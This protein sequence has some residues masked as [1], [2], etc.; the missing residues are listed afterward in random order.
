LD[1]A[2]LV[3]TLLQGGEDGDRESG[4]E[5]DVSDEA[6]IEELMAAQALLRG[7]GLVGGGAAADQS[8]FHRSEANVVAGRP[9]T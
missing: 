2:G 1:R 9:A 5:N 4:D 6:H 7:G 3:L 8:F